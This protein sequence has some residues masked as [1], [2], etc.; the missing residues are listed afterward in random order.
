MCL[1]T[2]AY[3][4]HPKYPLILAANRDEFYQRST[5]PA[6]FWVEEGFPDVLAGKDL[7]AGG[8]WLGV[9]PSGRWA[10]LTNYRDLS[11]LKKD[12]PSRGELVLDYLKSNLSAREYLAK[13][14]YH[15]WVYND[16]NLLVG[17]E[18]EVLYYSNV[19]GD[20]LLVPPGVHGLSN[21]FLNTSWPKTDRIVND[22]KTVIGRD[23]VGKED[24]F[25]IL[26]DETLA[27]DNLLPSTGL[28]KEMEKAVSS[29][30]IRTDGYGTRCS[31]V[32]QID[33]HGEIRFT[34]RSFEPNSKKV[35]WEEEFILPKK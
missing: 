21:A 19:K 27:E 7:S 5:R 29:V 1:L 14:S 34:E 32:L 24:L 4:V 31:T 3:K 30:F 22:M 15:S 25:R 23:D 17:D 28:I 11:R 16:F 18:K 10:A 6:R 9:H 20:I 33:N 13:I 8:T 35:V 26:E 12:P 2:I